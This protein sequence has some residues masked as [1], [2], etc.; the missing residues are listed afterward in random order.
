MRTANRAFVAQVD[1][2]ITEISA[3]IANSPNVSWIN[4]TLPAEWTRVPLPEPLAVGTPVPET[5]EAVPTSVLPPTTEAQTATL[6]VGDLMIVASGTLTIYA[7]PSEDAPQLATLQT[8]RELIVTS[9]PLSGAGMTWYRVQ[10]L[11]HSGWIRD[12]SGLQPV[13]P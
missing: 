13:E 9:E 8:G 11:E 2:T 10:T 5:I 6:S 4:R 7:E 12:I 3:S 1:G